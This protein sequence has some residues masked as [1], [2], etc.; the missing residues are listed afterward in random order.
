MPVITHT[1]H[2]EIPV[3]VRSTILHRSSVRDS[4]M[5][6][7]RLNFKLKLNLSLMSPHLIPA[8]LTLVLTT[9]LAGR[10]G[11]KKRSMCGSPHVH[12]NLSTCLY[13]GHLFVEHPALGPWVQGTTQHMSFKY[14]YYAGRACGI[15][16]VA[17][18]RYVKYY[19]AAIGLTWLTSA[20]AC[21][22]A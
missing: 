7:C 22:G 1:Q 13:K 3:N 14:Q 10:N 9:L 2:S 20:P 16:Y 19:D 18:E 5:L 17:L 8:S 6:P 15:L 21:N 12:G 11:R 4:G